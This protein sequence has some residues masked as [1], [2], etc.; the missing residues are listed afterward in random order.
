MFTG[1][2]SPAEKKFRSR[3]IKYLTQS[4]KQLLTDEIINNSNLSKKHVPFNSK[5]EKNNVLRH[6]KSI[7]IYDFSRRGHV[8]EDKTA[9]FPNTMNLIFNYFPEFTINNLGRTYWHTLQPEERIDCHHDNVDF[10][11]KD[12]HRNE[13]KRYHIYLDIPLDAVI[14]MDGEL[15]NRYAGDGISNTLIEFNHLDFHYYNNHS[16]RAITFLVFDLCEK[17]IREQ[18]NS[19]YINK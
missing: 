1:N 4:E 10:Y 13:L 12:I 15:R 16:D 3:I 9:L 8:V 18:F 17:N 5:D 19:D 6:G 14:V 11:I 2:V 7:Y